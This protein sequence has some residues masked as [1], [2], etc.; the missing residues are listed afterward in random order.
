MVRANRALSRSRSSAIQLR[1]AHQ[2]PTHRP[3][4]PAS[5]RS[6]MAGWRRT[7]VREVRD[8]D[9]T[10]CR[11]TAD[12][13]ALPAAPALPQ[14]PHRGVTDGAVPCRRWHADRLAF[15]ALRG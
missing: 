15:R 14:E 3:R 13:H 10:R 6:A 12:V 2:I 4:E 1:L 7:M 11:T 5:A 9:H 8:G